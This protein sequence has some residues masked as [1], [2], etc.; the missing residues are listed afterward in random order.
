MADHTE[1]VELALELISEEGRLITLQKL[2]TGAADPAKP[3]NGSSTPTV[4]SSV[5]NVPAIFV[6]VIGKDLGVIV[7]DQELLKKVQQVAIAAPVAEGLELTTDRILDGSE[8]W[9]VEW[10]QVLKPADKTIMYLFGVKR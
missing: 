1:F 4:A 6:P 2:G 8:T 5:S 7:K 10:A 3:W 9:R